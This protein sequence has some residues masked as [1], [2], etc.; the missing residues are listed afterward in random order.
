M[1]F[2]SIT[3][4]RNFEKLIISILLLVPFLSACNSP[5][6]T[7]EAPFQ[8]IP[9]PFKPEETPTL[10]IDPGSQILDSDQVATLTSLK[11]IDDYPL[12]T[13]H[14]AGHYVQTMSGLTN[15][16]NLN[17]AWFNDFSQWSCSLFAALGDNQNMSFGRNFDWQF[18]PAILLF[19]NPPDSYASV[20]MVDIAYLGFDPDQVGALTELSLEDLEPLLMAPYLPF[21]G[22][23]E[24]GLAIGMAAV[25]FGNM[26]DDPAKNTIDSLEVIRQILDNAADIEQ[27][28]E[29]LGSYNIDYGSGPPLHY[30]IADANGDAVL[31]EFY[32]GQMHLVRNENPW[33]SATNFLLSSVDDPQGQ[34][35][36][37]DKIT[38]EIQESDGKLSRTSAMELLSSVS[39]PGTQWSIIYH[40]TQGKIEVV[41][42]RQFDQQYEF[43][44]NH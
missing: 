17:P 37:Y 1:A 30:L 38:Q 36:R 43:N 27:A 42:G 18:S 32:Q 5:Q 2:K 13:M 34:C 15:D 11:K 28:V 6:R 40:M 20:S 10:L 29:I 39:Q 26:T 23:N 33:L 35:W 44:L 25:P 8:S 21:D 16:E 7:P 24:T 41:V 9:S 14:F 4:V 19:T 12:Y 22:M 31:V 3:D